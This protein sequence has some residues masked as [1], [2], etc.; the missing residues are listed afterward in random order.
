M[1]LAFWKKQADGQTGNAP[2]PGNKRRRCGWVKKVIALVLV[3]A[4]AGGGAWYFLGSG[5]NSAAAADT[6]YTTAAVERRTITST[7]TGSGTLEAADSY[8][9]TTLLEGTILT[10]N[11]EE[12]DQVEKDTVLYTIDSTDAENS[13]E[14]SQ[15]SVSQAQRNYN[16]A[17]ESLDDLTVAADVDGRIYSLDVEV[18]DEIN[19]GEQVATIRNSDVMELTVSFPADD[20]QGFYVGQSAT[21]TLD[22]TFETLTGTVSEVAANTTVSTGNMIVREVTIQVTNP[23]GI[24]TTQTASATVNGVGSSSSGTFSYEDESTVVADVSGTVS[25]I[26]VSEGDWVS[27]GQTLLV[28]T[29]DDLD[30]QVQS[31]SDSLRNAEISYENQTDQ[32]DDYT[33][34]S[35]I[36]GTIVDKNYNAGETTEANEVLCTIYDLSYLTMT[37]SVDELDISD[38]EVGQT[39]TIVADAVEDQ[40]YEGVVTKVS[41][42]GTSSGSATTYPVTIRIDETDGLL[43]GMSVDATIELGSAEDV[44]AIPASALNRGDTVLV[45]ADS[46]SAA[47]AVTGQTEETAEA[48]A[49][50]AAPEGESEEQQYVSVPVTTGI[51]DGDYIEITSGLQEGDVVAYIPTSGSSDSGLGMMMGGMPSGGGMGGGMPG[52]GGPGG[53]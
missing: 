45:T 53:F 51:T 28:M 20:A 36:Q 23:G 13:L 50:S 11:F 38:I 17:L 10:A 26:A 24:S 18:G 39:V 1:K 47:N 4:I 21:V 52:G 48:P 29:S 33:I 40:T 2:S 27:E 5:D 12:G 35:P 41:V 46:P 37:L 44:L 25:S 22:S 42:A 19:A 31:A 32:L 8:S 15:I 49:S 16:S 9:V 34:T 3:C 14:Q 6:T 7:I 43:P 30:E